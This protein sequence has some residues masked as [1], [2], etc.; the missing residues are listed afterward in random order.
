[1]KVDTMSML[2]EYKVNVYYNTCN[3]SLFLFQIPIYCCGDHSDLIKINKIKMT[4]KFISS[5]SQLQEMK[6]KHNAN[7]KFYI[8]IHITNLF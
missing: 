8:P 2:Q 4:W 7:I 3:I 1:M 6:V 5:I